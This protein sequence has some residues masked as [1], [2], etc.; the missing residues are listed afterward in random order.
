VPKKRGPKK[1]RKPKNL[2]DRLQAHWRKVLAHMYEFTVPF[3]DK[4]AEVTLR[5]VKLK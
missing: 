5:L 3:G 4:Q 1:Q 2:L